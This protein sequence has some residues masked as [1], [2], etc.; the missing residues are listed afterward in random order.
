MSANCYWWNS[1]KS[2]SVGPGFNCIVPLLYFTY[3]IF[4]FD[5]NST[6]TNALQ[7]RNPFMVCALPK[8]APRHQR[9]TFSLGMCHRSV[10]NMEKALLRSQNK[11][12]S[13]YIPNGPNTQSTSSGARRPI[14]S[15]GMYFSTLLRTSTACIYANNA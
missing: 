5:Y 2:G 9:C 14:P 10:A 4:I 15:M 12:L 6:V 8:A 11:P 7:N 13:A 3:S 1:V